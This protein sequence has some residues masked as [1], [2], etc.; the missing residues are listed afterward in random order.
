MSSLTRTDEREARQQPEHG[1]ASAQ[2][3]REVGGEGRGLLV[4]GVES[5]MHNA[6]CL[7]R[8]ASVVGVAL[9]M[10]TG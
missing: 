2:H 5:E 7:R 3:E 10:D 8:S 4:C 6:K 9:M 1:G